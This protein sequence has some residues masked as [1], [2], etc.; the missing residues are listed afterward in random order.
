MALPTLTSQVLL[1]IETLKSS[2]ESSY[3]R[4]FG[5]S[6]LSLPQE[7]KDRVLSFLCCPE[8]LPAQCTALLPQETWLG[9]LLNGKYMSYLWDLDVTA[10]EEFHDAR[11]KDGT[12]PDWEL[13]VRK[14][15]QGVWTNWIHHDTLEATLRLL[16]YPKLD[17]SNGLRNRRR[18]WQLVEEMYVGDLLPVARTW[19]DS[20]RPPTMPLYWDEYGEALFP[21]LRVTGVMADD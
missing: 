13:L 21:V 20:K 5:R 10:I 9:I 7:L 14:L 15:S 11:T 16:C 18:I 1:N 17:V 12:I 19:I 3:V 4:S 8:G 6:F 2:S